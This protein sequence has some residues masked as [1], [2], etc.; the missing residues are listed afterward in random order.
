MT[1]KLISIITAFILI[2]AGSNFP[3]ENQSSIKAMTDWVLV[4]TMENSLSAASSVLNP[5]AY[6]NFSQ[7]LILV[8]RG[9]NTY[10]Q[11]SGEIWYN[12]STDQGISWQRV[13]PVNSSLN[14]S[15]RY[16][17]CAIS[18]PNL[19]GLPESKAVFTWTH[20]NTPVYYGAGYGVDNPIG[21]GSIISDYDSTFLSIPVIWTEADWIFWAGST[22]VGYEVA[23]TND[24]NTI[25][26]YQVF[27]NSVSFFELGGVGHNGHQFLG[28]I[29][30]FPHPNPGNPI[31]S[32]FYPGYTKSTDNGQT[33]SEAVVVDF[34]TI[35][36][37]SNFDRLF[38]YK[39]GDAA[40]SYT[41]DINVD[42]DGYVHMIISVTDTTVNNN[43]GNNALVEIFETTSGW[44][45]KVIYEGIND[46]AFTTREGPAA[47]QMGPS[48]Y[49]AFDKDREQMACVWVTNTQTS[50]LGLCDIYLSTRNLSDN[51][52]N[53]GIN[54][55]QTDDMNENGAHLASQ[56]F[57]D[58]GET[59]KAF[60][61]YFYE[62]DYFGPDP[63]N[64]EKNGFWVTT[65]TF[66]PSNISNDQPLADNFA[67]DQN[68]PNPFNP[69]TRIQYA[70]GSRQFVTLKVYDVLGNEIATLVNEEKP[71][72]EYEIEFSASSGI[73]DL[74]SG[75]Y[76]YQLKAGSFIQTKKMI[77]LK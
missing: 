37:L 48:G 56:L 36:G 28:F 63:N 20:V 41:G 8:H 77:L 55:T 53:E 1:M 45:G 13:A 7:A 50:T 60:V 49:L 21:S 32:G 15:A 71:A 68:Y 40:V 65:I 9:A 64:N 11:S 43:T 10:A 34:R 73:R 4:D 35:T 3:Q 44:E 18:N 61:G 69:S 19:G 27:G 30:N 31:Y 42:K 24:F 17:S 67:L 46:D 57:S 12:L 33:W 2:I 14:L 75:I 5:I 74:V 62:L 54:I 26:H 25:E 6:D 76:L 29:G 70:I 58:L 51:E 47:G 52:W 16:P 23:R 39:K 72:G 59:Y 66:N 22:N 38:D